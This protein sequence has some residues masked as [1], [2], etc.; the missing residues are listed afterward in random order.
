MTLKELA[1]RLEAD[2]AAGQNE[3][4]SHFFKSTAYENR[5]LIIKALRALSGLE[6]V[7]GALKKCEAVLLP[8]LDINKGTQPNLTGDAAAACFQMTLEIAAAISLARSALSQ[9]DQLEAAGE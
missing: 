6:G 4:T 2:Q 7:K 1:D 9:L 8:V 3:F 5:E